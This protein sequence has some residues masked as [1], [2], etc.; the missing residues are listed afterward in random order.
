[1]AQNHSAL[2]TRP[3]GNLEGCISF[4]FFFR[5]QDKEDLRLRSLHHWCCSFPSFLP[6]CAPWSTLPVPPRYPLKWQQL[7]CDL[8]WLLPAL[9]NLGKE[10]D[11][12][13][14][15]NWCA[16]HILILCFTCFISLC[17]KT[18]NSSVPTVCKF[19]L[20]EHEH[21]EGSTKSS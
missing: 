12:S 4:F 10:K 13:G 2:K 17:L 18:L 16:L 5:S 3:W 14:N 21:L 20:T 11:N 9:H 7:E 6:L 15:Q 8:Q 19:V 1:M